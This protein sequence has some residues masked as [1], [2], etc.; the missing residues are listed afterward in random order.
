[1]NC[2]YCNTQNSE[3]A[4]FC[5]GC[6]K[7]LSGTYCPECSAQNEEGAV[8]CMECGARID[9]RHFCLQCGATLEPGVQICP[10]CGTR[11]LQRDK[12]K[13]E[14]VVNEKFYKAMKMTSL[15]ISIVIAAFA[16]VFVIF[17]G[18]TASNGDGGASLFYYFGDVWEDLKIISKTYGGYLNSLVAASYVQALFGLIICIVTIITVFVF[19]I[20]GIIRS[21]QAIIGE[22][23]GSFN[24]A[25][26]AYLA[27][28]GGVTAHL[29][30]YSQS[31]T[32]SYSGET[33]TIVFNGVTVIGLAIGGILLG[34]SVVFAVLSNGTKQ[35]NRKFIVNGSLSLGAMVI[36][37]I[38]IELYGLPFVSVRNNSGRFGYGYFANLMQAAVAADTMGKNTKAIIS[39]VFCVMAFALSCYLLIRMLRLIFRSVKDVTSGDGSAVKGSFGMS[40]ELFAITLVMLAFTI[41]EF[42]L[43]K[44]LPR[45]DVDGVGYGPV[46]GLA[47]LALINLGIEIARKIVNNKLP[48]SEEETESLSARLDKSL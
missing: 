22:S 38:F 8:Y 40:I 11:R 12:N 25:I 2:K 17:M 15:G 35:I 47:V 27:Y 19:G 16:M 36:A 39:A 43:L 30:L 10:Q 26:G 46:I 7:M 31:Q 34:L 13:P 1:M 42:S 14:I 4:K 24:N 29:L 32:K 6:G 28:A 9:G 18:V 33:T 20:T 3:D 23:K 21:V 5:S 37:A 41:C 48:E 44:S 45:M